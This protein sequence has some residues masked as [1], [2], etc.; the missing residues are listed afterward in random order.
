GDG[1]RETNQDSAVQ[2]ADVDAQL[3]RVR[4]RDPEQLAVEELLLDAAPVR[5]AVA[6]A[7]ARQPGGQ[8]VFLRER[9]LAV[10]EDQFGGDAGPGER[11][12]LHPRARHLRQELARLDE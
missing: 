7:I 12:V 5:R 3:E 11:D 6:G 1:A 8:A 9:R 4:R 2:G 10:A